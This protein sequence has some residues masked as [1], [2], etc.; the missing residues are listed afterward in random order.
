MQTAVRTRVEALLESWDTISLTLDTWTDRR[1][2]SYLGITAHGMDSNMRLAFCCL[3]VV[4]MNEKHSGENLAAA[5]QKVLADYK[6]QDRVLSYVTDHAANVLK[7]QDFWKGPQ[8][9]GCAAHKLNLIA[10]HASN[11]VLCYSPRR[12]APTGRPTD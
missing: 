5:V 1:T 9:I 8:L 12:T 4:P 11:R 2:R 10:R 3:G 7:I 6:M